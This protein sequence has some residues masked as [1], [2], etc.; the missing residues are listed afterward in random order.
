[1]FIIL[2]VLLNLKILLFMHNTEVVSN[3]I[4]VF[5]ISFFSTL[6]VFSSVYFSNLRKK[7]WLAFSFYVLVSILMF[8]DVVYYG[9]LI[10]CLQ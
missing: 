6:F 7:H 9:I 1:M 4:L 5:I 10:H 8:V 3:G 2:L